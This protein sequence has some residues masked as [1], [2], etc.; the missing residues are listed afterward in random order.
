M[1]APAR[2]DFFENPAIDR[3]H[4][5]KAMSIGVHIGSGSTGNAVKK[6]ILFLCNFH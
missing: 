1:A 2:D 4:M 5:T 3:K 6:S